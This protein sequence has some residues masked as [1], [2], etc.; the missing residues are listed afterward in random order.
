MRGAEELIHDCL[1]IIARPLWHEPNYRLRGR[2]AF[3][4]IV[5]GPGAARLHLRRCSSI[6]IGQV[7]RA[8][9]RVTDRDWA[10]QNPQ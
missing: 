1:L 3:A 8:Y 9:I 10:Q 2:R 6:T 4:F 7:A 5:H